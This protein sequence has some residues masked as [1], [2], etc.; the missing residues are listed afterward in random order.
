MV[1]NANVPDWTKGALRP[2]NEVVKGKSSRSKVTTANR[3][4][5]YL[6]GGKWANEAETPGKSAHRAMA[7][8]QLLNSTPRFNG[9]KKHLPTDRRERPQQNDSLNP[10][11]VQRTQVFV[12]PPLEGASNQRALYSFT[13]A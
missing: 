6:S 12:G 2:F 9:R 4:T 8:E 13:P 10:G 7:F 3:Y 5:Q 11:T 1:L